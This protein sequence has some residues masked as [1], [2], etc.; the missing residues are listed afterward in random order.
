MDNS[1]MT[2]KKSAAK[3]AASPAASSGKGKKAQG[4][5]TVLFL[6]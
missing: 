2:A 6:K 3:S 5:G 4:T 1:Q